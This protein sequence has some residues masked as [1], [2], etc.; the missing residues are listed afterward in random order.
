MK[1]LCLETR[2]LKGFP[3]KN[4]QNVPLRRSRFLS[5]TLEEHPENVKNFPSWI[6]AELDICRVR[7]MPVNFNFS[8]RNRQSGY[9]PS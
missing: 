6:Y 2:F 4:R 7:Y 9:M 5:G 8:E 3:Y 1:F